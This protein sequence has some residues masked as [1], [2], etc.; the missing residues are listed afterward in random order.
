MSRV[1]D[2]SRA[3]LDLTRSSPELSWA[4]PKMVAASQRDLP[5]CM[6]PV[7]AHIAALP[8]NGPHADVIAALKGAVSDLPWRQSY[9]VKDGFPQAWLDAYGWVNFYAPD[10][11]FQTNDIRI[12]LGYWG[13]WVDYPLHAHAAVED[14]L[15]LSGTATF[16][17]EGRSDIS[18]APGDLVHVPSWAPHAFRHNQNGLLVAAFWRG[19]G[20]GTKSKLL[21]RGSAS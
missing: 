3:L 14:Y 9:G 5:A 1:A 15:V 17:V 19:A 6:L 11:V 4:L 10:G 21:E 8:S 20:L 13:P 18:A 12:S 16:V 7:C 2:L